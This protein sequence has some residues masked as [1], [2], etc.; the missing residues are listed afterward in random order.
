M[1][2]FL[3]E[4]L[5]VLFEGRG[6]KSFTTFATCALSSGH[7]PEAIFIKASFDRASGILVSGSAVVESAELP[8]TCDGGFV[9]C[10]FEKVGEGFFFGVEVA[11]VSVVSEVILPGHDLDA[12]GRA[13]RSGVAVIETDTVF[14]ESVEMWC[15]VILSTV[16]G[17]A[18]PRDVVGHDEDDVWLLSCEKWASAQNT[19]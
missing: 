4:E 6:P 10:G 11:E 7:L 17:E 1:V 2:V 19:E 9:A 13:D 18:L 3:S 15:F 12:G 16:A 14:S 8:L 5:P